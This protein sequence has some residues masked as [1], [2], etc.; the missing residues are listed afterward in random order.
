MK[1]RSMTLSLLL[2]LT[3]VFLSVSLAAAFE[4]GDKVLVLHEEKWWEARLKQVKGDKY[5]IQY[6][7]WSSP[8]EEW[9]GK[10]RIMEGPAEWYTKKS[11]SK[12]K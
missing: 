11:K 8:V 1:K 4:P 9:V 2:L 3:A 10:D 5:L 12:T 7:G 6:I